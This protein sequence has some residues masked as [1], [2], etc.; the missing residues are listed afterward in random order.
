MKIIQK[1]VEKLKF[2]MSCEGVTIAFLGDSVTQGCFEVYRKRNGD[3]E[4]VFEKNFSYQ[5]TVFDILATL[6]PTVTVNI[7]NA[8]ISGD[9]ATRG[10]LRVD[11]HVIRHQPDLTVV[12]Y[13]LND[14]SNKKDSVNVYV[15]A[16]DGIFNKLQ[17][18]GSEIIFMTPNMMN[19]RI[20]DH[21]ADEAILKVAE[22]T[23]YLQNEGIFDAHIEA[24]KKLCR[25]NNIP[26]CDCYALWK[27]L[28][29]CGVDT[30]ELLSNKI[31]HPTREMNKMFAYE[32][33]KTMF[34]E[35]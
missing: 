18:C 27:K 15:N 19:T 35:H 9:Q 16:L 8:G 23:A 31:N 1:M 22:H 21:I 4:T 32:L 10:V 5:M 33:V 24:A 30:T 11:S 7:V 28:D 6:F 14:C 20:S 12:C 3:I 26:I 25:L 17:A 13:G 34:E 29:S 2:N